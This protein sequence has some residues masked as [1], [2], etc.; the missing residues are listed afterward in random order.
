MLGAFLG[1]VNNR[2][3]LQPPSANCHSH[4]VLVWESDAA[5]ELAQ[6]A[7]SCHCVCPHEFVWLGLRPCLCHARHCDSMP[8]CC[9]LL[10]WVI[11]SLVCACYRS[12]VAQWRVIGAS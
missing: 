4:S 7:V 9:Q 6:L 5:Y 12:T 1:F 3:T 10:L 2:A 8:C 11:A